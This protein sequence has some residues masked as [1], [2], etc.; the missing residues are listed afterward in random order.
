[1]DYA[2]R[3]DGKIHTRYS[4]LLNC[5]TKQI[6]GIIKTRRQFGGDQPRGGFYGHSNAAIRFGTLRHEMFMEESQQT[7]YTPEC[8]GPPINIEMVEEELAT[9]IVP[10]VILHSRPDAVS[11]SQ[12][13][14]ID[15]KTIERRNK[16]AIIDASLI[17]E[18]YR[19]GGGFK[20][21]KL[22]EAY[23]RGVVVPGVNFTPMTIEAHKQLFRG[24]HQLPTYCYQLY[25][26]K[27][28]VRTMVYMLEV[29][30]KK[31]ME[32]LGYTRLEKPITLTDIMVN[33]KWL[34]ERASLLKAALKAVGMAP[35]L[36]T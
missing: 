16:L 23:K 26:N 5:T 36:D 27:H 13:T 31:N 2:I 33:K 17:P 10:G 29:W 8:F 18:Q 14:V 6:H 28:V 30:D 1:M 22:Y 34:V 3:K 15:Y 20:N 11:L 21:R 9:E 24:S 32:I 7:G 4:E 35:G 19:W 25:A 12:A